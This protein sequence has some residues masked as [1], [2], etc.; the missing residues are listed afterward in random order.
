MSEKCVK[1]GSTRFVVHHHVRYEPEEIIL[2]CRVCHQ[3]IH[4]RVRKE[5]KCPY[6]PDEVKV[7]SSRLA[8]QRWGRAHPDRRNALI[9]VYRK[10]YR[11]RMVFHESVGLGWSIREEISFNTKTGTV[12]VSVGF[13]G[14]EPRGR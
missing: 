6:T 11:Q 2:V 8:A 13:H 5:G 4:I 7:M 1:C 14:K 12:T 3:N 10:Q 9:R